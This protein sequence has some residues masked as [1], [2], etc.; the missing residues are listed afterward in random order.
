MVL[1][2]GTS[3]LHEAPKSSVD[4]N[5]STSN[6]AQGRA[7]APSPRPTPRAVGASRGPL[8]VRGRPLFELGDPYFEADEVLGEFAGRTH[9]YQFFYSRSVNPSLSL[10]YLLRAFSGYGVKIFH[11][12]FLS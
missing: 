5:V 2:H 8:P 7:T 1:D 4:T 9:L 6:D 3:C 11:G 10:C 12:S